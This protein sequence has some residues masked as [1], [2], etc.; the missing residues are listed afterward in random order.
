MQ[1]TPFKC[2]PS[3]FEEPVKTIYQ[4]S[5]LPESIA[6]IVSLISG[7]HDI[8]AEVTR[9]AVNKVGVNNV[10]GQAAYDA[11]THMK[12]FKPVGYHSTVSF[13]KTKLQGPDFVVMYQ[14]QNGKSVLVE[15]DIYVP[16]LLP[17]GKDVP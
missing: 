16:D 17:G 5:G 4:K 2:L 14:I 9:R 11:L 6:M 7:Y 13:T 3:E 12:D 8:Y 15:K 10:D 1:L